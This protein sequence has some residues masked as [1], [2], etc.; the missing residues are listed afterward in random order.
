MNNII[1]ENPN[2]SIGQRQIFSLS[3]VS[4][5]DIKNKNILDIGCGFGWFEL[6]LL[7]RSPKEINATE[8]TNKDLYAIRKYVKDKR[9]KT[10]IASGD[11]LPFS[12]SIFNTVTS[13][14]VIEHIPKHYENKMFKEINRVLKPNGVFYLSTPY[15]N[16]IAKLLDPAWWLIGHRH[17]SCKK[18]IEYGKNNGFAIK[19]IQIRGGHWEAIYILNMYIAKWIFRRKP[20]F[21]TFFHNKIESEYQNSGFIG[22]FIKYQKI[23]SLI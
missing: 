19:N 17:Y 14:D 11:K 5:F 20:L 1:N 2:D 12:A 18:L 16:F 6:R 4:D 9:V 3:F 13:W 21:N 7:N 22:I 8:I 23:D 15:D 10:T